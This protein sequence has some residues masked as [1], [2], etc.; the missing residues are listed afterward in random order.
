MP[1]IRYRHLLAAAAALGSLGL[2]LTPASADPVRGHNAVPLTLTCNGVE[3]MLVSANEP[4]PTIHVIGESTVLVATA[5][6]LE[7]SF[8]D[9]AT[10][11]TITE[12]TDVVYGSGHGAA[13]DAQRNLT[14]CTST[15]VIEDPAVGTITATLTATVA[16]RP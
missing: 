12:V 7:L 4:T 5:A 3:L 6:H 2:G 14:T 11:Q 16:I 13:N 1:K 10:G 8:V 9:P 15:Q